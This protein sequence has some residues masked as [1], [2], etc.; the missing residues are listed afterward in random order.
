M[1]QQSRRRGFWNNAPSRLQLYYVAEGQSQVDLIYIPPTACARLAVQAGCVLIVLLLVG[2]Q[3]SDGQCRIPHWALHFVVN[4]LN[5]QQCQ[6]RIKQY[7]TFS[8]S[9]KN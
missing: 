4:Y 9:L 2:F 5:N 7:L 3:T 1:A 6:F 8:A